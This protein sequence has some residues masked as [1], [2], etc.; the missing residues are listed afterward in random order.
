[1]QSDDASLCAIQNATA[2]LSRSLERLTTLPLTLRHGSAR[3]ALRLEHAVE[4]SCDPRV[5][6]PFVH[7]RYL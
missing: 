1:V 5:S 6:Q 4:C 2:L 7:R 3:R